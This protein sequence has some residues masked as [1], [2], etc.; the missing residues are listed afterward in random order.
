MTINL[1]N[2]NLLYLIMVGIIGYLGFNLA[3]NQ[4]ARVSQRDSET[5]KNTENELEEEKV[6]DE[7]DAYRVYIDFGQDTNITIDTGLMETDA[8]LKISEIGSKINS[9]NKFI[10]VGG[11][12]FNVDKIL[13]VG[14]E[15][16]YRWV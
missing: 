13:T 12:L 8:D 6:V 9:G 7:E 1:V 15:E 4:N 11:D 3:F 5:E 16:E 14:K 2:M 10:G